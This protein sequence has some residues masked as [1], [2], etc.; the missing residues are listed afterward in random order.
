MA[1]GSGCR[2]TCVCPTVERLRVRLIKDLFIYLFILCRNWCKNNFD[3]KLP[4]SMQI[5]HKS[6][7]FS[8]AGLFNGWRARRP[9]TPDTLC[10]PDTVGRKINPGYTKATHWPFKEIPR[11]TLPVSTISL[12]SKRW[13]F[14]GQ[15]AIVFSDRSFLCSP[16]FIYFFSERALV[17]KTLLPQI[18]QRI[19]CNE[20]A[21]D[22]WSRLSKV[23]WQD[24]QFT[25]A[26][27]KHRASSQ[28]SA[29]LSRLITLLEIISWGHEIGYAS[30]YS[31]PKLQAVLKSQFFLA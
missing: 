12:R 28:Q 17:V 14:T 7:K 21:T 23:M 9:A 20:S 29:F 10:R 16:D 13:L 1:P 19:Q 3:G 22:G 5:S 6:P 26:S 30:R 4:V 25:Y 8:P 24:I 31:F 18:V 15:A 27:F 11:E 2:R